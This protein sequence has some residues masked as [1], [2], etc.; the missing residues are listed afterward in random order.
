MVDLF[1]IEVQQPAEGKEARA[2]T[3]ELA[4][5][6]DSTWTAS[7]DEPSMAHIVFCIVSNFVSFEL[8]LI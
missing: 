6:D 3:E 1:S 4:A 7:L 5:N 8:I 2:V